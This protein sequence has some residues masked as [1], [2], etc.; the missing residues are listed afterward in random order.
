M[1][2]T[3]DVDLSTLLLQD[4]HFYSRVHTQTYLMALPNFHF[5]NLILTT[6]DLFFFSQAFSFP[7]G[8]A[9]GLLSRFLCDG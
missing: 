3:K 2:T 5:F 6:Y 4:F 9:F 7:S 8:L 1:A